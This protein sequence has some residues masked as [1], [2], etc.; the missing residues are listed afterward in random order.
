MAKIV[1]AMIIDLDKVPRDWLTKE[2]TELTAPQIRELLLEDMD[3]AEREAIKV[4][5]WK[6]A[7]PHILALLPKTETSS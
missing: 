3:D 6:K 1:V 2:D 4:R 5:V 7:A